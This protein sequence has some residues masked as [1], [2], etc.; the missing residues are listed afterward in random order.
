M[1]TFGEHS[2]KKNLPFA[3]PATITTAIIITNDSCH[4]HYVLQLPPAEKERKKC[5]ANLVHW[6]HWHQNAPIKLPV[7]GS[8]G[9]CE[10]YAICNK[11]Y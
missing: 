2:S 7:T 3:R 1:E 4:T 8:T 10:L 6:S 9:I 5:C 11:P